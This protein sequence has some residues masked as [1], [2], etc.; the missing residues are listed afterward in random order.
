MKKSVKLFG[1]LN[2]VFLIIGLAAIGFAMAGCESQVVQSKSTINIAAIQGL[3][4]PVT[5]GI[6]V[7]SI[8]E[9][10]QYSGTVT[11]SPNHSTFAALTQYTA[12]IT[13]TPKS[14]WT[15]QGVM[16]FFFKVAGATTVRNSADSG[17]IIA[18]F[19]KT[20]AT[21]ATINIAEIQGFTVPVIGGIPVT[22][23]TETAQ[24]TGT[25]TWSP[26]HST[27]AAATQ[28]TATITLTPK[29]GYTLQGVV[30]NY[31]TVAGAAPVSNNANSGVVTAVFPATGAAAIS[32]AAI[33]GVTVPVTG[34]T[35]VS[36]ITENEQYRG[37]V[38]WLPNIS[39]TFAAATQYAATITLTAKTGWTLKGVTSNFFTLAGATSAINNDNSGVVT[40]V[41]PMTGAATINVAAIQ[42]LT[43]PTA[44]GTPVTNIMGNAQYTGT[45]TWS[46]NHSIF[47]AA[48]QYT[49]IITL[50]PKSGWTLQGVV[51]DYFTVSGAISISNNANSEVVTVVFPTTYAPPAG[52]VYVPGG[53]FQMGDAKNLNYYD[54][55]KPVHTVTMTGFCIG[56]YEVTQAQ[57]KAV[58]GSNP[59]YFSSSPAS[60][61]VQA[62]RPV[63]CVSWY[64]A[65][66]FCNKLSMAEGLSPAY[67]ISGSTNPSA[68]GSVPTSSNSMW[69]AVEIVSGSNGYRLPTEAQWEY[70]AKGGGGSPGNYTY[71]GSNYQHE[72]GWDLGNSD[73]KTH[74][75]GK[76]LANGLGIFDMSGNVCEWCWDWYSYYSSSPVANPAGPAYGLSRIM[77]GGFWS[78]SNE[79]HSSYRGAADPDRKYEGFGFRLVRPE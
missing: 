16:A 57:Y 26:N 75:V 76:K 32:I 74:E 42:G 72:V 33:A 49:A 50:M 41:F 79:T 18:V 8:I 3:T 78:S 40:A 54:H 22:A 9:N 17:V 48:T 6:P 62:N 46:P 36:S 2:R 19:P 39:G 43:V 15:M 56:K 21:T 31:F 5:G 14:G 20:G 13:L 52:M 64:D 23:I 24:Y 51:V 47:V 7:T 66:V 71:S 73:Y 60:L 77:R 27:F 11:W 10:E 12:T 63:E 68:W 58:M 44:G 53:S 70:A 59:S 35:P 1:N 30:A 25:V 29:T 37:T 4:V 67:R 45:V 38:T 34:G 69:D 65:I 55:E 61:E 28:Y